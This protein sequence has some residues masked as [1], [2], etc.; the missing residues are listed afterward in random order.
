[1][2]SAQLEARLNRLES[3]L[4]QIEQ[5]GRGDADE[6]FY[7]DRKDLDGQQVSDGGFPVGTGPFKQHLFKDV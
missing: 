7:I 2:D 3:L 6:A 5:N 4:V 1:M